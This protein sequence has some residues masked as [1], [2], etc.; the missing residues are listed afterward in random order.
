V[1][2]PTAGTG[3]VKALK[4]FGFIFRHVISRVSQPN[5]SIKRTRF[6]RRLFQAL[7]GTDGFC[8]FVARRPRRSAVLFNH[9][10]CMNF[11]SNGTS[12]PLGFNRFPH[13][14]GN[15]VRL[16]RSVFQQ[17]C[18]FFWRVVH[19]WLRAGLPANN[20]FKPTP[21]RGAA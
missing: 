9:S 4:I 20:S 21:L 19:F 14:R 17:F 3:F 5:S 10:R 8:A 18:N 6:Q 13:H 15:V 12:V 1:C 2:K 7:A 16:V 11:T